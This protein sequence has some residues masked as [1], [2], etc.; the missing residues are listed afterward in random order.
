MS[1][2]SSFSSSSPQ[3]VRDSCSSRDSHKSSMSA[4]SSQEEGGPLPAA[5]ELASPPEATVRRPLPPSSL[6]GR[7]GQARTHSMEQERGKEG[8]RRVEE[9]GSTE[10]DLRA[11]CTTQ[12]SASFTSEEL[13][14]SRKELGRS[15]EIEKEIS[16]GGEEVGRSRK[17]QEAAHRSPITE[18]RGSPE[19]APL[20][21]RRSPDAPLPRHGLPEGPR[22]RSPDAPHRRSPELSNFTSEE[23]RLSRK[24]LSLNRNPDISFALGEKALYELARVPAPREVLTDLEDWER[25]SVLETSSRSSGLRRSPLEPLE[26]PGDPQQLDTLN[27]PEKEVVRR[28]GPPPGG[29]STLNLVLKWPRAAAPRGEQRGAGGAPAE[30]R[31]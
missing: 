28:R 31:W 15:P 13:R 5:H 26:P 10:V 2:S 18:L 22:R 4:R 8:R 9:E 11:G 3:S 25:L 21:R 1:P 12:S 24:E 20:P 17:A 19:A 16:F 6:K 14:Q 27:R 30:R 29:E 7:R 23:L